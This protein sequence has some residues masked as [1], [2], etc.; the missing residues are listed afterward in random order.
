M[1]LT[2]ALLTRT[3][4]HA[5][6][7]DP[8]PAG[9]IDRALEAAVAAPN[10]RMTE[11]WRFTR[12]GPTTRAD[13]ADIGVDLKRVKAGDAFTDTHAAK[14]RGKIIAPPEMI[15]VSQVRCDQPAIEREDYAAVACAIQNMTLSLWAEGIGTKWSSGGVTTDL[16]TYARLGIDPD[17]EV[18]CGFVMCGLPK[19]TPPKPPRKT[20]ARTTNTPPPLAHVARPRAKHT[21]NGFGT[22]PPDLESGH[23]PCDPL[24]VWMCAATMPHRCDPRG[25]ASDPRILL[26]RRV[27]TDKRACSHSDLGRRTRNAG[28]RLAANINSN[29]RKPPRR[30]RPK[31]VMPSSSCCRTRSFNRTKPTHL[32]LRTNNSR[33]VSKPRPRHWRR[34]G[35]P[36]R[37]TRPT[38]TRPKRRST[39][40]RPRPPRL[41]RVRRSN[42]CKQHA[43]H[44][45]PPNKPSATKKRV[46]T[47]SKPRSLDCVKRSTNGKPI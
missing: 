5:F 22:R 28:R 3:T 24:C 1:D 32:R 45:K 36:S 17:K 15:V 10:H 14:A 18:I 31:H 9:A 21:T 27:R 37:K 16:R 42:S 43:N 8:L 30:S 29:P 11:P 7:T 2:H 25:A 40:P 4:V 46:P 34:G 23:A 20:P 41:S 47:R 33:R 19:S 35:P 6:R 26:Q 39:T 38:T 12:V 13:I 44:V